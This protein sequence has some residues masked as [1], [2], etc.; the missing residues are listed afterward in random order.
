VNPQKPEKSRIVFECAANF[1]GV[2]LNKQLLQGPDMTNKLVGVLLRFRED[3]IAY[4]ADIEAMF[5]KKGF[6]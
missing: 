1:E 2:S 5:V 4:L 3:P 6:H